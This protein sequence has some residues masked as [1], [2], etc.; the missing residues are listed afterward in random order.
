[1]AICSY[2]SKRIIPAPI[3][4]ITKNFEKTGDGEIKGARFTL[5]ITGTLMAFKGSPDSDGDFYTGSRYDP[6]G[7]T[8]PTSLEE[9]SQDSRV[10]AIFR[11]QEALREL[12]SQEGHSLE[13]QAFDGSPPIKCNPRINSIEFQDGIWYDVCRYTINCEADVIYING[14]SIGEDEFTQYI[15]EA[16]ET[17]NIDTSEDRPE[18][19]GLPRTYILSHTVSAKGKR[20]YDEAGDLES[21]AWE[22]ARKYVVPRL[23]FDNNLLSSSGVRDLPSYYG[24]FNHVRKEDIGKNDGTYSVS[25]TWILSSG[26]ALEDF[27]VSV[28]RDSRDGLTKVSIDGNITGLEQR[29]AAMQVV[30]TKFNNAETKFNSVSGV[31]LTRAQTYSGET[32]NVFPASV[33][34]GKNPVTGTITY[35]YEYDNRPTNYIPGAKSEVISISNNWNVD[36]FAQIFVLGRAAGP[37]LQDLGSREAQ[38]TDLSIEVVFNPAVL[39]ESSVNGY[40]SIL[41]L[42]NPR[43]TAAGTE[44]QKIVDAAN[45]VN[46]GFATAYISTQNESWE[47][48]SGRYSYKI[49]Y[50]YE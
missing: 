45:P 48:T 28:T 23:G 41:N 8:E 2:N 29:S 6:D 40:K 22:Q 4:S 31:L 14:T 13:F 12:F 19:L 44:I 49:Q 50:V 16:N 26:A 42:Q 1:M 15:S 10:A 47:P 3:V 27:N 34:L 43:F 33:L 5:T 17:W 37:V 9:I 11:K 46:N 25:E 32:L 24:G 18:G 36:T 39:S 7:R 21:P 38:T 30:S 35:K 20:F